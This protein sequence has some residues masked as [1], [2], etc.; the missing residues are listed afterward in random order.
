MPVRTCTENGKPGYRCGDAGRCYTYSSGD[1]AGR[2]EAKR[3][4]AVQCVAIGEDPGLMIDTEQLAIT[5]Q[6]R[7]MSDIAFEGTA[8]DDGRYILPGALDWREL[9]LTL[10][11]LTTN[12]T[13]SGWTLRNAAR[14]VRA[15]PSRD[16]WRPENSTG[17]RSNWRCQAV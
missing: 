13:S 9:P 15:D 4:A 8:T 11:A 16:Q 10:M 12:E 6:I 7:W 3:K 5:S 2:K 1:E 14:D 17:W